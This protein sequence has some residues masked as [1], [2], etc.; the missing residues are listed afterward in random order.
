MLLKEIGILSD[1]GTQRLFLMP[2]ADNG[3]VSI[4]KS[5]YF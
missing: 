1:G 2:A 4:E 5:V 3:C